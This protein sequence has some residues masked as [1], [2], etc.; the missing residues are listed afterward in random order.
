MDAACSTTYNA[1]FPF[2]SSIFRTIGPGDSSG[3]PAGAIYEPDARTLEQAVT[4]ALNDNLL[5]PN[6]ASGIPGH[7]SALQY[8]VNLTINLATTG[9]IVTK[10]SLRPL[11]YAKDI[12]TTL[13]FTLTI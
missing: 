12:E 2:Q 10:V 4:S 9:Q 11:G 5:A 3:R 7:V 6:N 8:A 1:Q 13:G